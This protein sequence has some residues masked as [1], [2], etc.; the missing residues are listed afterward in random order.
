MQKGLQRLVSSLPA[1]I[2]TTMLGFA[3]D[4]TPASPVATPAP[5]FRAETKL[6]LVDAVV[7]DK[8]GAY[9][10]DLTAKDFRVYEDGKEQAIKSFSY[11]ADP[12]TPEN[13]RPRYVVFFFD[14]SSMET[15]DQVQARMAAAKFID[16]NAGPNR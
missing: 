10:H 16:T 5:T 15:S 11:E 6:V 12:A 2:C 4:Q 3:Q 13:S 7:T 9:V 8:K 1:L 14:N